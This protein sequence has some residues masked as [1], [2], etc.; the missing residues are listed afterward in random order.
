MHGE[1]T[2]GISYLTS[3]AK[4]PF[5]P[6]V[7]TNRLW[8]YPINHEKDKKSPKYYAQTPTFIHLQYFFFWPEFVCNI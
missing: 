1:V 3:V 6:A 4:L 8:Q 7:I 2:F 5:H